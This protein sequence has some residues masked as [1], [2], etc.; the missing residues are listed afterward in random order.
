[1]GIGGAIF[2]VAIG[3]ILAFAVHANIPWLDLYV[4]GWV[5]MLSGVAVLWVTLWFWNARRRR[6]RPPGIVEQ[7]LVEGQHGKMPTSPA[8]ELRLPPA[9]APRPP[10]RS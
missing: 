8:D 9:E 4:V 6:Q 1:M 3:A 2:L 5:L 7:T 10:P